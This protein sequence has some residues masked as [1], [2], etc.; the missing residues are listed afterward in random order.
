VTARGLDAGLPRKPGSGVSPADKTHLEGLAAEV[1][2]AE[3]E[4]ETN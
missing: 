4:N 2:K 1:K 3:E